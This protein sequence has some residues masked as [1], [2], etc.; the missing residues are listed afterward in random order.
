MRS[1]NSTEWGAEQKTLLIVYRPLIRSKIY[2][3]CKLFIY[4]SSR[5]QESLESVPNETNRRRLQIYTNV[6]PTT[7]HKR[8][9]HPD[10]KR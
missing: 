2:Y 6:E 9:S 4:A 3:G 10:K 5:E 8:T 7:Y 1:V